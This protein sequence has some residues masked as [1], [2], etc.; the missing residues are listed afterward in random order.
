MSHFEDEQIRK[1]PTRRELC[2]IPS[3][4]IIREASFSAD[5]THAAFIARRGEVCHIM[6]TRTN[7]GSY[8]HAQG[9]VMSD[10]GSTTGFSVRDKGLAFASLNGFVGPAFNWMSDPLLDPQGRS[11]AYW[12]LR[13]THLSAGYYIVYGEDLIGP[14]RAYGNSFFDPRSGQ[15]VFTVQDRGASFVTFGD[16]RSERF[17][18]ILRP[19][20]HPRTGSIWFWGYKSNRF[21]LMDGVNVVC[22]STRLTSDNGPFF[23]KDG[24]HF[25]CWMNDGERWLIF[26]DSGMT[27]VEG[28]PVE[29]L[30][31][32]FV[33]DANDMIYAVEN[34][35]RVALHRGYSRGEP[36]DAMGPLAL[37]ESGDKF[38]YIA[39]IGNKQVA[40]VNDIKGKEFDA[41]WPEEGEF[42][43]Y[44]EEAIVFDQDATSFAYVARQGDSEFVVV[45]DEPHRPLGTLTGSPA[46]SPSS[47]ALVY[48]VFRDRNEFVVVDSALVH[49]GDRVWFPRAVGPSF[50]WNPC[51]THSGSQT[52]AGAVSGDKLV[53]FNID[54]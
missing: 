45:N 31:R 50:R 12:G 13:Q 42:A 40:I 41:I 46:F 29:E 34:N 32:I 30:S 39:R 17:D 28:E 19:T 5:G 8:E 22:E 27:E 20:I 48:G 1:K 37:S 53:L 51:F 4:A 25:A 21:F 54:I 14:F 6:T 2:S 24:K 11:L 3:G 26:S 18:R 16:F 9:L 52:I 36:F 43:K 23:S 7:L 33:I 47:G 49:V 10:D 38:G 44:L 15:L 35:S